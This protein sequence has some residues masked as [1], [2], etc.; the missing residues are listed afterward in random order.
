MLYRIKRNNKIT[1]EVTIIFFISSIAH[2][3]GRVTQNEKREKTKYST[4]M[5]CCVTQYI[6]T[7]NTPVQSHSN[8]NL[9][10]SIN[11]EFSGVLPS[12]SKT[13]YVA[14]RGIN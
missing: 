10:D 7:V 1:Y 6:N 12:T 13:I 5:L 3:E 8:V 9:Y 2:S 4:H 11:Q 14:F